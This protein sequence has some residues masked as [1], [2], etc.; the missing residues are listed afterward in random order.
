IQ[1]CSGD[2]ILAQSNIAALYWLNQMS[3]T[4]PADRAVVEASLS[5]LYSAAGSP[6]SP[7]VIWFSNPRLASVAA[8]LVTD[9]R[10]KNCLLKSS[11]V[12]AYIEK[13]KWLVDLFPE[14]ADG[15]HEAW[16]FGIK[17][18]QARPEYEPDI[19]FW[20]GTHLLRMPPR[21]GR[22]LWD[23]IEMRAVSPD[24]DEV[25]EAHRIL[26]NAVNR[27][28]H[29]LNLQDSPDPA[30]PAEFF[31][32]LL[33][34]TRLRMVGYRRLLN[35]LG[36]CPERND[37]LEEI[38]ENC[39]G[40]IPFEHVVFAVERPVQINRDHRGRLH[41][42]TGQSIEYSDGW[43][44]YSLRGMT[45]RNPQI[46]TNRASITVEDID[47]E[48]NAEIR[49]VMIQFYGEERYLRDSQADIVDDDARFGTLYRRQISRFDQ[50]AMLRVTNSTSEEDGT[51]KTYFLEVPPD[52]RTA[53]E[54]VAWTFGMTDDQYDPVIE[55]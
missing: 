9:E 21:R 10:Q 11:P 36:A 19:G 13:W 55:T 52:M 34:R 12:Y 22:D 3:V 42:D 4:R 33:D 39:G 31:R 54:A 40:F 44:C 50:I 7:T 28:G 16:A 5:R 35:S 37:G 30:L 32:L 29:D 46:I 43:G 24:T 25:A 23:T 15:S 45:V 8:A 26:K 20:C 49:S 53:H 17:R 18:R 47:G 51:F 27:S 14:I 41:N 2:E 38:L 48:F 1:D 6:V